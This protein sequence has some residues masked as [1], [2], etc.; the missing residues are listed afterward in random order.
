M[1]TDTYYAQLPASLKAQFSD[2]A[3][4]I[5]TLAG[6]QQTRGLA[7]IELGQRWHFMLTLRLSNIDAPNTYNSTKLLNSLKWYVDNVSNRTGKVRGRQCPFYRS[8]YIHRKPDKSFHAHIYGKYPKGGNFERFESVLEEEWVK[9]PLVGR[10]A[11]EINFHLLP[12][13][14]Q[15]L[16]WGKYGAY[17]SKRK[18]TEATAFVGD[19]SLPHHNYKRAH[20]EGT[21]IHSA[22]LRIR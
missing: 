5:S 21:R 11:D 22:S 3:L 18:G 1:K 2:Y 10:N 7:F 16:A 15:S 19:L 20:W 13:E 14:R 8:V 17:V 12:C 4:D 6:R 9:L